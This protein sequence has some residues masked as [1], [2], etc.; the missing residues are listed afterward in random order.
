[1]IEELESF[2]GG[3]FLTHQGVDSRVTEAELWKAFEQPVLIWVHGDSFDDSGLERLVAA[4]RRFPHIRRF[5]FTSTRVTSL[6]ARRLY[7]FWPDIP[8]EG[9]AVNEALQTTAASLEVIALSGE[10][11]KVASGSAAVSGSLGDS[12]ALLEINEPKTKPHT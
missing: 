9:V 1:M 4:A 8:I 10:M 6:G 2:G 5:R 3:V 12:R 11:A 7:E